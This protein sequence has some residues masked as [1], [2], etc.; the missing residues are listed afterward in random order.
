M[1]GNFEIKFLFIFLNLNVE[2]S[3]KMSSKNSKLTRIAVVNADRCKPNKCNQE[4]KN[5]CPV[6]RIGRLCVDVDLLSK[7]STISEPVCIGCGIC[8]KK[9]PFEA[10]SI[11]NLPTNL[12][13]DTTHRYGPNSF[14]LHRLPTP[15]LG[16]VVGLI[17]INGIG[18]STALSILVGKLKPNLGNFQV[19]MREHKSLLILYKSNI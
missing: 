8:V 18:K 16:Q 10:I 7:I 5:F 1:M 12:D 4:C 9:C 3:Q 13:K 15:K 2:T 11:I 6:N 17:G 19:N 14:K